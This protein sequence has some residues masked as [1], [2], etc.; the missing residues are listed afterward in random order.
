MSETEELPAEELP[1]KTKEKIKDA[2]LALKEKIVAGESTELDEDN[3]VMEKKYEVRQTLRANLKHKN[4]LGSNTIYNLSRDVWQLISA[5]PIDSPLT[6]LE[7]F[8][9]KAH[10]NKHWEIQEVLVPVTEL[11]FY[12]KFDGT[13]EKPENI[14]IVHEDEDGVKQE[15]VLNVGDWVEV[16]QVLHDKVL[17][18][19]MSNPE[20]NI[21]HAMSK[22]VPQEK[23]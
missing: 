16:T 22:S 3:F 13:L 14:S 8:E 1:K 19:S 11:K 15:I 20:R 10:R 12:V 18:K 21:W 23:V 17:V 6:D 2:A 9:R 7:Y 4:P 5:S